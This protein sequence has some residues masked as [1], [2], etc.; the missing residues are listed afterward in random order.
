MHSLALKRVSL[1]LAAIGVVVV[2]FLAS[3]CSDAWVLTL[4]NH[5]RSCDPRPCGYRIQGV[6]LGQVVDAYGPPERFFAI[7]A[8]VSETPLLSV[9]L[10]YPHDGMMVWAL[11]KEVDKKEVTRDFDVTQVSYWNAKSLT[12]LK[13]ELDKAGGSWSFE[14]DHSETW[15]GF[16]P[17]T[18][19]PPQ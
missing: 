15:T 18:T 19:V 3:S 1:I 11:G 5:L 7:E 4:T 17:V 9:S 2:M 16:G 10:I 8:N 12:D 13:T 6:K 14:L